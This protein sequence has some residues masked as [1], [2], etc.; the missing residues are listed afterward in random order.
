[1][2]A[3]APKYAWTYSYIHNVFVIPD[4]LLILSFRP[5]SRNPVL[6]LCLQFDIPYSI[7]DIPNS[8]FYFS[9]FHRD[10]GSSTKPKLSS[11]FLKVISYLL[12]VINFLFALLVSFAQFVYWYIYLYQKKEPPQ[13][14]G[15]TDEER[16]EVTG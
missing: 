10:R 3:G 2:K 15:E 1:M 8:K 9:R 7:F 11:R 12:S 13:S 14:G 5:L 4:S 16:K 6:G